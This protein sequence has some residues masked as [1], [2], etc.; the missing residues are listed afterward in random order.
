MDV[1]WG[2]GTLFDPLQVFIQQKGRHGFI[3]DLNTN[4]YNS[5]KWETS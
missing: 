2:I 3:E 1:K 4:G 5:P